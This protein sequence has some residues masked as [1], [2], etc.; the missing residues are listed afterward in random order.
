MRRRTG[1]E[2]IGEVIVHTFRTDGFLRIHGITIKTRTD[3]PLCVIR[4]AL[5][6]ELPPI[7]L[8]VMPAAASFQVLREH[9]AVNCRKVRVEID[10]DQLGN[11]PDVSLFAGPL[12]CADSKGENIC[13]RSPFSRLFYSEV[14]GINIPACVVKYYV[15]LPKIFI[16]VII[17]NITT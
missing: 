12:I 9:V 5:P 4:C 7:K 2:N 11:C 15:E 14:E 8:R 17:Y 3:V 1:G 16:G 6:G 10:T 13:F